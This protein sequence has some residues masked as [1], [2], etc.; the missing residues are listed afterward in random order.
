VSRSWLAR[1]K[2]TTRVA[3][4][5]APEDA[6][7]IGREIERS[8]EHRRVIGL[9][10]QLDAGDPARDSELDDLLRLA[11]RV[12]IDE[13]VLT[14]ALKENAELSDAIVR[15]GSLPT[16]GKLCLRHTGQ[17]GDAPVNL[18]PISIHRRPLAGSSALTKRMA[19]IVLSGAALIALAPV[20]IAIA[21]AIRL[22]SP[23]PA[24]YRQ[25]RAGFNLQTFFV[26]KFRTM[27]D[28]SDI[29]VDPRV[30]QA[31]R[32]DLRVTRIG[33]ILRRFSL[34][35]L[36][37]LLNVLRGEMSLVGPRPHAVPHDEK[38]SRLI[39]DYLLRH[40][41]RPGITGWAQVNGYRGKTD[42]LADMQARIKHDLW[43]IENW[44][45]SL[46]MKIL[47][48]TALHIWGDEAAY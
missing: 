31:A 2:L 33:A 34:D 10:H 19:D 37:Q 14:A 12:R 26:Y 4:F 6:A 46:D 13:I 36:P 20:L 30:P 11:R 18:P 38:Y 29:Y 48:R 44:S 21:L 39:D 15:L 45:L 28:D 23:G 3:V 47:V 9:F 16:D 5:G 42:T 27:Y 43:Y 25:R 8:S 32:G 41:V 40:R 22:D 1:G 24:I 17:P 7:R 35:E